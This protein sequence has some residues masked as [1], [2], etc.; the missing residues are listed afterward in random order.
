MVSV[1][2]KNVF[3]NHIVSYPTHYN[4]N[5]NWSYGSLAGIFYSVQILTGLILASHYISYELIVFEN[6]EHIMRDVDFGWFFRYLHLNGA[7]FFFIV[8]YLHLFRGIF[9]K[10]Y[11]RPRQFI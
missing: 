2:I 5:Y 4:L 6:L 1:S 8:I 7:S 3:N 11:V 9:Y 10:S